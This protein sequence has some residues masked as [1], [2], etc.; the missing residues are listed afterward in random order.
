MTAGLGLK[1]LD[2]GSELKFT[3]MIVCTRTAYNIMNL[4]EDYQHQP[5]LHS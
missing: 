5:F 3:A 4:I 2:C 1:G